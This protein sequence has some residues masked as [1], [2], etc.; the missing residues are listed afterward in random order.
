M[1]EIDATLNPVIG[2]QTIKKGRKRIMHF[3]GKELTLDPNF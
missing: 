2:R 1:E 3:A